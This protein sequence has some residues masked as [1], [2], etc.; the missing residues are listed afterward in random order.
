[1]EKKLQD[2]YI[3]EEGMN[4]LWNVWYSE[5]HNGN[6]GLT[7]KIERVLESLVSPFQR[8]EVLQNNDFGKM[9]VLYGSLMV[10]DND[11]NAYNEMLAHVPLFSHPSPRQVLIIG[12][13]DCGC[14]TEV[15]AHPEVQ[16]CTMCEIDK[17]VVEVS[18]KHFPKLTKGLDDSRAN[19]NFQDGKKF[20]EESDQKFDLV[21]LDL[22][23]PIGPAA[24]LFQ[25]TFH[26]TVFDRLNDDGIMVA[27][28]ESPFF[29]QNT[30]R[31]MY[32]NLK[33]IFP[34]VKMYTCFMPIYPSTLWSFAFCSKKYDPI[35]DFDKDRLA[36]SSHQTQYYNQDIHL[37]SFLLPQ[38]AKEL[39][40]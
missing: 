1:M 39:V 36:K 18:K 19:L 21:L 23:D 14:L 15:L 9:L 28:T 17:M 10:A 5:L 29:N 12:G 31:L 35:D 7:F 33:D 2:V 8:I 26:Q 13:G 38:F 20:I 24:D 27:Q 40:E 34:I 32:K 3:S 4:D 6:S 25:K 22:S 11:K 16:R 30:I 37:G